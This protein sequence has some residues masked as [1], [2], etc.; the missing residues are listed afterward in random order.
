MSEMH[1]LHHYFGSFSIHISTRKL[2]NNWCNWCSREGSSLCPTAPRRALDGQGRSRETLMAFFLPMLTNV[3]NYIRQVVSKVPGLVADVAQIVVRR[4]GH[5]LIVG[6][7]F[8]EVLDLFKLVF[9][10]KLAHGG[11]VYLR[12]R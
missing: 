4:G 3:L 10:R 11:R 6:N 12:C 7:P 5:G 9:G 1:H 8:K 2:L